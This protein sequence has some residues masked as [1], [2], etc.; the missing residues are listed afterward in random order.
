MTAQWIAHGAVFQ[1]S[2]SISSCLHWSGQL[3]D[4]SGVTGVP[5]AMSLSTPLLIS[6]GEWWGQ[7]GVPWSA[8]KPLLT[9]G[10]RDAEPKGPHPSP[11]TGDPCPRER[12]ETLNVAPRGAPSC[13]RWCRGPAHPMT[14]MKNDISCA[15]GERLPG[16]T[17]S[18]GHDACDSHPKSSTGI[19]WWFDVPEHGCW[20]GHPASPLLL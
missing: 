8:T 5:T 9:K 15:G 19:A 6:A 16:S 20:T 2:A 13:V 7:G 10:L 14:H 1:S 11:G 4:L 3:Q 18:F 12:G 17:P